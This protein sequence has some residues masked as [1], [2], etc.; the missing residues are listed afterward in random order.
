M[1]EEGNYTSIPN[2]G[3]LLGNGPGSNKANNKPEI[4][5]FMT[6]IGFVNWRRD[7]QQ[8]AI[9]KLYKC[10][11]VQPQLRIKQLTLLH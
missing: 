7:N 2:F 3:A 4:A 11:N 8:N 10:R 6:S 5:I 1:D 9:Q